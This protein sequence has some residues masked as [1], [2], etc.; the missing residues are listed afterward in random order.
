MNDLRL[1]QFLYRI[2]HFY[3]NFRQTK[4]SCL[5]SIKCR[6]LKTEKEN[7]VISRGDFAANKI[8]LSVSRVQSN[9]QVDDF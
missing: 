7:Q 9:I 2:T 6:F 1:T 5:F 3:E 8:Y 4:H